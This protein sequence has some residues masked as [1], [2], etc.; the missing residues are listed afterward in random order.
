MKVQSQLSADEIAEIAYLRQSDPDTWTKKKIAEE[1][2]VSQ[3]EVVK[4]APLPAWKAEQ[5]AT[6]QAEKKAA[7]VRAGA[8]YEKK[9]LRRKVK[10]SFMG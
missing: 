8:R 2:G 1:Y 9:L 6:G 3:K 10:R 7:R 4:F 5:I